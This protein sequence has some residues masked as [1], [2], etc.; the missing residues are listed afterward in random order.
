MSIRIHLLIAAAVA[1]VSAFG[2][3]H[4]A[5]DTDIAAL[6]AAHCT[7]CHSPSVYTRLDRRVNSLEALDK[8][9]HNC[10]ASLGL[11]WPAATHDAMVNYLN[12]TYYE[13]PETAK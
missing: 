10:E 5:G 3:V 2:T 12:R 7:Q 9:V 6:H 1:A 8:Q 11:K 13:Y 4:A